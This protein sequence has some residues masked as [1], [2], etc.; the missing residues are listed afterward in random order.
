MNKKFIL[1]LL[2]GLLV[3]LVS[4]LYDTSNTKADFVHES[5]MVNDEMHQIEKNDQHISNILPS[6]TPSSELKTFN[7]YVDE[8]VSANGSSLRPTVLSNILEDINISSDDFDFNNAADQLMLIM[9]DPGNHQLVMRDLF[10]YCA[11]L[12][13][14]E[15]GE[16]ELSINSQLASE[17]I[18]L[19]LQKSGY[20]N[21]IG[22]DSDPF[23]II[24]DLARKGDKLAQLYL[25]DDLHYAIERGLIQP[26]L[27]PIEY[28]DLRTEIIDYLKSLSAR[29]VVRATV[30]LQK[31]YDTSNFLFPTDPV[32]VYY[33][34][35]LGEKQS[36]DQ[37]LY[38]YTS[39]QLYQRLTKSQ[40]AR[41]DR[42]TKK[43]KQ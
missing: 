4:Y 30:N 17:N 20:C 32:L 10:S 7:T 15:L 18:F 2:F 37:G 40:K 1:V 21:H 25:I 12:K 36:N 19:T 42:I 9:E 3:L 6:I 24:L 33:Y 5:I 43:L 29:G 22:T 39:D 26:K 31:V 23:Y 16:I 11:A 14:R 35:V 28:N 41:A 38:F 8:T 13:E 27:Y 34:T